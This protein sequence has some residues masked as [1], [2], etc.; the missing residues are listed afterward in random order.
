VLNQ[1][2]IVTGTSTFAYL[3]SRKLPVESLLET[4]S[5]MS[6][7]SS[8]VTAKPKPKPKKGRKK[9][10]AI[11][12][13]DVAKAL[14]I[15]VPKIIYMP[16]EKQPRVPGDLSWK[17]ERDCAANLSFSTPKNFLDWIKS[18]QFRPFWEE[19]ILNRNDVPGIKNAE[20]TKHFEQLDNIFKNE[21]AYT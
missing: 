15:K 5:P 2:C 13:D 18:D 16:I 9:T 10:T 12:E 4:S 17:G 14:K 19:Y 6:S 21:A 3:V 7:P 11:T 8:Q 20:P 1:F